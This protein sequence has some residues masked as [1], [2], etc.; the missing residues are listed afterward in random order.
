MPS[1]K[2]I[3]KD[4]FINFKE[5]GVPEPVVVVPSSIFVD[6]ERGTRRLEGGQLYGTKEIVIEGLLD[7]A[8]PQ[9][10]RLGCRI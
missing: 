4:F 1:H 8:H 9:V 3:A 2:L 6:L 5:V 10:Y 7:K